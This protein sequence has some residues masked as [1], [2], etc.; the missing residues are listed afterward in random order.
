VKYVWK[1][2]VRRWG[3]LGGSVV[4]LEIV[5]LLQ[6]S[7]CNRVVSLIDWFE[8]RDCFLLVM[9]KPDNCTDLFEYI[10]ERGVLTEETAREIF[11]QTIQAILCCHEKGVVHRDIK[12]ENILIDWSTL[13]IK[14]IDFGS[15]TFLS[16]SNC[17][18][19]RHDFDGTRVYSPPEWVMHRV[20][21]PMPGTVWSLGVLLYDMVQ[22]DIPFHSDEAICR[23]RLSL[24]ENI[25][26]PCKE[27]LAHCL[28]P[29]P[30]QRMPLDDILAHPWLMG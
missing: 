3:Q 14:L 5:L 27:L 24:A 20:Y 2:K 12:D 25:S 1:D 22:G 21:L 26:T 17:S 30:Y 10:S 13:E 28:T 15:S 23:G 9:E 6:V 29:C 4:P 8:E 7:S 19:C 16:C 18:T 11:I